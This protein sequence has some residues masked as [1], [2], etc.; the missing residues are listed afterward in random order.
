MRYAAVIATCA[1]MV[2]ALAV[3]LFSKAGSYLPLAVLI[4][5]YPVVMFLLEP[6]SNRGRRPAYNSGRHQM[7]RV[8]WRV[9]IGHP[10]TLPL[11]RVPGWQPAIVI[12]PALR[13]QL[14]GA[15]QLAPL[16]D[17]L[18]RL[19]GWVRGHA[20][21]SDVTA[22]LRAAM[23]PDDARRAFISL[24]QMLVT[25]QDH[26]LAMWALEQLKTL[27]EQRG[28]SPVDVARIGRA[29]GDADGVLARFAATYG[30]TPRS[31]VLLD[32]RPFEKPRV[33]EL[34]PAI[35]PKPSA[36]A[37]LPVVAALAR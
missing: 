15:N 1:S 26:D 9:E 27:A 31:T 5:T 16:A 22:A 10:S 28:V 20:G 4:A 23:L 32:V 21:L 25:P 34:C 30:S 12:E 17:D 3:A 6:R 18:V 13:I 11:D 35:A 36:L 29:F 19:D 2:V 8:R 7:A 14:V 33:L 24:E 37:W